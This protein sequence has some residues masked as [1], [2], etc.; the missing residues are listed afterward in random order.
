MSLFAND[1]RV[2][3]EN[4]TIVS[5]K[6]LLDLINGHKAN[7]QKS[8]SFLYTNNAISE[9]E[10]R[11]KNPIYYSNNE[12]KVCRNKLNQRGKRPVLRKL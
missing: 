9:T 3:I 12:N 1:M 7:I 10:T 4:P 11:E 8:K 6:E 2:Y 5:T